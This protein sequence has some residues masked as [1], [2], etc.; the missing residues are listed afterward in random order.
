MLYIDCGQNRSMEFIDIMMISIIVVEFR[1]FCFIEFRVFSVIEFRG[2][3]VIEY[4][5]F[6]V[7]MVFVMWIV[8]LFDDS[9]D[10]DLNLIK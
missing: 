5:V 10:R 9:Y 2:F 1:E 8:D 3:S 4:R 7:K 6:S